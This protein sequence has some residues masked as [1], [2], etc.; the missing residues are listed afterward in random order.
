MY[1]WMAVCH[2]MW[3]LLNASADVE[4]RRMQ[5]RTDALNIVLKWM[6]SESNWL[7]KAALLVCLHTYDRDINVQ[8]HEAMA[9]TIKKRM[10]GFR[11]ADLRFIVLFVGDSG[12]VRK[13][14]AFVFGDLYRSGSARGKEYLAV[15]YLKMIRY[16]YYQVNKNSIDLPFVT[17]NSKEEI[18]NIRLVLAFIMTRYDLYCQ[19]RW[20][21]QAYLEEIS[22]YDVSCETLNYITAFFYVLAKDDYDYQR[23]ILLFLSELKGRTAKS[24]YTNLMK[25]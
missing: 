9:C 2:A 8:L 21:L 12:N 25:I 15:I 22:G 11:N 3:P 1:S 13:V 7:W 4:L 6:E 18:S 5:L 14:M 19:L 20:I 16:G 17:C 24:I 23:D 10:F